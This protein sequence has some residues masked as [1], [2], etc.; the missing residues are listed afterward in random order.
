M[1][2]ENGLSE[3]CVCTCA[4]KLLLSAKALLQRL[5]VKGFSPVWVLMCPCSSQGRENDLPQKGHL[6]PA[7][8]VRMCMFRAAG[9]LYSLSQWGQHFM[10]WS[11]LWVCRWRARL[12]LL[13]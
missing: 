10:S 5:H 8:W 2:Q 13:L 6:Q 12:L 3:E 11:G 4:L 9:L 7:V 1:E